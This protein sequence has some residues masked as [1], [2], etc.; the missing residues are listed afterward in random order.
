MYTCIIEEGELSIRERR[1][2]KKKE[3]EE[4]ERE[5]KDSKRG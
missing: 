3:Q 4:K 2:Q 5:M 1:K